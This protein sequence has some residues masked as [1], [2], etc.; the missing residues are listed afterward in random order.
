[1][2]HARVI[3][4]LKENLQSAYRKAIDADGK[5]DELKK[6]GHVKFNT[7]FTKEEGFTTTSNRFKPYVQELADEL[8]KLPTTPEELPA[9]L[10]AFVKKLG[11]LIQTL[12]A[13][14]A[15]SK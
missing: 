6:A 11:V 7:I 5:L 10:E 9:A 2:P 14:K 3:E 15:Q 4:Q 1:M 12:Q 8:D 13:F